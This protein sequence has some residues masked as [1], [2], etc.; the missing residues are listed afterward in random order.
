MGEFCLNLTNGLMNFQKTAH[1]EG[2]NTFQV[3]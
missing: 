2:V 3:G 1:L